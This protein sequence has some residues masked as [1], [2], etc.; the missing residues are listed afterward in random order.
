MGIP[1]GAIEGKK[2]FSDP[3]TRLFALSAGSKASLATVTHEL[4]KYLTERQEIIDLD[5]LAYTLFSRRFLLDY[6]SCHLAGTLEE[7]CASLKAIS[8][9]PPGVSGTRA[10]ASFVFT[11]QGASWHAMGRE[12]IST[13]PIFAASLDAAN[14][15]L[16]S[17]GAA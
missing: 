13:Y 6:R 16:Q 14:D 8:H 7:L 1:R 12:L 2:N 15:H 3:A 9:M 10:H 17:L 4:L 5:R 11:G